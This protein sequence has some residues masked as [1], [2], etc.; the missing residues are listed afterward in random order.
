MHIYIQQ[1]RTNA[2]TFIFWAAGLFFLMYAG[3]IKYTGFAADTGAILEIFDAWPKIIKAAFGLGSMDF[4][5]LAGYYG[6]LMLYAIIVIALYA[7]AL[8]VKGVTGDIH[9]K[10][11]D[12]IYAKP[13]SR[14]YVLACKQAADLTLII[15]FSALSYV[16]S[17]VAIAM[18]D[19][20]NTIA[21]EVLLLN[22]GLAIVGCLYYFIG[23]FCGALDSNRGGLIANLAV[24]EGYILSVGHDIMES[25]QQFV[26]P[27][28]PY[29]YYDS[30]ILFSH[31]SLDV[32][33]LVLGAVL[34]IALGWATLRIMTR[35]DL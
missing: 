15:L 16:F 27:L 17:M 23:S 24:L 2:K 14:A 32:G 3:M 12:F 10:T 35:K 28:T 5:T 1:L 6:V 26:R 4:T 19:V 13:T 25:G 33:Y 22:I 18:L 30:S 29:K 11:A 34:I 7:V 9:D 31:G 21:T 20:Q 8:G